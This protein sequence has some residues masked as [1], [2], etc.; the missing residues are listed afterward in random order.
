MCKKQ[1]ASTMRTKCTM[2]R[3]QK[4]L[5]RDLIG[6]FPVNEFAIRTF[7]TEVASYPKSGEFVSKREALDMIPDIKFDNGATF[8]GEAIEETVKLLKDERYPP[9]HHRHQQHTHTHT[10]TQT[11]T[12]SMPI[13]IS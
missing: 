3:K 13:S 9:S 1:D 6:V 7:A 11:Y 12:N 5:A 4:D 8:T 2:H 10:H